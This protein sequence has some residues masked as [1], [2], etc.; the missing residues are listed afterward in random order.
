MSIAEDLQK[1]NDDILKRTQVLESSTIAFFLDKKDLSREEYQKTGVPFKNLFK[2]SLE[3]HFRFEEAALYPI[4]MEKSPKA[5]QLVSEMI[6]DHSRIMQAF[7][8][9][10]RIEN[11]RDSVKALTDILRDVSLHAGKENVLYSSIS[12]SK[13]E[14]A[15]VAEIASSMGISFQ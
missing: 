15:K 8:D 9:F 12:L 7:K 6:S 1:V 3:K 2:A 5:R 13:N 11:Y 10:E 4:I 14:S